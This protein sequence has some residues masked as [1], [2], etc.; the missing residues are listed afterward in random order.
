M[1]SIGQ[2]GEQE[3]LLA[4]G[5]AA[6]AGTRVLCAL[7]AGRVNPGG[8]GITTRSHCKAWGHGNPLQYFLVVRMAACLS[9]HAYALDHRNGLGACVQKVWLTLGLGFA[10]AG[11][12]TVPT[13]AACAP[14]MAT[15]AP[16]R[17][18]AGGS[19]GA[20]ESTALAQ[21]TRSWRP[22]S[23]STWLA[24]RFPFRS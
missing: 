8:T 16:V 11:L 6:C 18:I 24:H 2:H 7:L 12:A 5:A 22:R 1:G 9:I 4:A 15:D 13:K 17:P 14:A 23:P 3:A 20:S 10:A 21:L 19:P